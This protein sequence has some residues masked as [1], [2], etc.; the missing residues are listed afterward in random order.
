MVLSMAHPFVLDVE[1]I[2]IKE[3]IRRKISS[4]VQKIQLLPLENHE[5]ICTNIK[6]REC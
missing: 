4:Q 6:F 2:T 3:Q 1:I 5:V